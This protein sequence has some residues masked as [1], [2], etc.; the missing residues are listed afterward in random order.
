MVV[1]FSMILPEGVYDLALLYNWAV[2]LPS[3]TLSIQAITQVA[4]DQERLE[5]ILGTL[6]DHI[7]LVFIED[8]HPSTS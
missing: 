2:D 1:Y 7:K 6:S 5:E 8:H 4:R 3:S